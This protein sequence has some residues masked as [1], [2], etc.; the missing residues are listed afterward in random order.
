MNKGKKLNLLTP[1]D[2]DVMNILWKS[3]QS[4]TA[5]EIVASNPELTSNTVQAVLRKLLKKELIKVENIVYSGTVLSRSYCPTIS[6]D[7]FAIMQL[8]SD[9]NILKDDISKSKLIA[10]L[11]E[12]EPDKNKTLQ[13]IAEIEHMLEEF[14]NKI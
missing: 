10:A 9:Y 6:S 3:G 5:S 8:T 11:L 13:D 2:L 1:R 7:D 14:K 4:M 12:S